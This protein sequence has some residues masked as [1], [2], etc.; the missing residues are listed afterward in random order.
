M[1]PVLKYSG[2]KWGIAKWIVSNM[3]A[4]DTYLEP[5]FGSGAVF[6]NKAPS[7]SETLGDVDNRIT[8][9]FRVIRDK[10]GELA[11]LVDMTPWSREEYYRSYELTGDEVEDARR[12]MI[13]CWMGFGSKTSDRVGWKNDVQGINGAFTTRQWNALPEQIYIVTARLKNAQIENQPALQLIERY[14]YPSVLIYADPPYPLST[15]SKRQYAYEMKD[16]DHI[17]LLDALDIHPGPV[18]LSS[19]A[20]PLYDNRLTHWVRRTIKG[21]A[22]GGRSREEVLWLNQTAAASIPSRLF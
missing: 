6:F 1:K 17:K 10:P 12:F 15:R 7:R 22:E 3:P 19:Y 16:S 21:R 8:N 13:R 5:Y 18:I 14:R 2:S 11:T 4:H 20:C 9:L